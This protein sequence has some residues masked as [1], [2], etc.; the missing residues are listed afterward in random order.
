MKS[1]FQHANYVEFLRAYIE[2]QPKAGRGLIN[3]LA[4]Y[5]NV[6][7]TLISQILSGQKHFSIEQVFEVCEFLGLT[8]LEKE[9]F[10]LLVQKGRAGSKKAEK[11]FNAQILKI[12]TQAMKLSERVSQDQVLTETQKAIFYSSWLYSA[13]RIFTAFD[14]SKTL[15]EIITEFSISRARAVEVINFLV[16]AGLCKQDGVKYKV[17]V[18]STHL[19]NR[20]PFIVRHHMN[21]RNRALQR[22]DNVADTELVYSAPMAL[23]EADFDLLREELTEWIKRMVVRVKHSPSETMAFLNIDFLLMNKKD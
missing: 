18:L 15:E 19:D 3:K 12:K 13:I 14:D 11:F 9:Y 2:S 20:S 17:G 6:H 4:L 16:E 5:L 7:A 1:I 21:W 10:L 23:S 8:N 22:H